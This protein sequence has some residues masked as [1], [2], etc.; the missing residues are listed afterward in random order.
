MALCVGVIGID[1]SG[2]GSN[3]NACIRLLSPKYSCLVLGWKAVS[4]I[5]QGCVYSL[6]ER[7]AERHEIAVPDSL[8]QAPSFSRRFLISI[9]RLRKQSL[10]KSL[11]P[12]FCFEDR[13][14]LVDPLILSAS[15]LSF[16]RNIPIAKRVRFMRFVTR[17]RLPD[18]YV[19]LDVKPETALQRIEKRHR[20]EGKKLSK[21]E[22]F[23]DLRLLL[24]QYEKAL[25][26]L[27]KQHIPVIRI[28]TEDKTVVSCSREI[29][30]VL[31]ELSAS[32][33]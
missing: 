11:K 2:K 28:N 21:H 12:V 9:Y 33:R 29:V 32:C 13:E 27:R 4:Y 30:T 6:L 23:A 8:Y 26:Y 7:P 10:I 25:D 31:C 17:G 18:C 24:G 22:N 14:L 19:Y 5:Y 16:L 1:G 20:L 3:I 15:Y